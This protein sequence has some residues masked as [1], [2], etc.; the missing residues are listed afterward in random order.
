[1]PT[2]KNR[3]ATKAQ[4]TLL[5]SVLA[6]GEIG[7]EIDTNKF[8]I[9]NGLS[10]WNQLKYFVDETLSSGSTRSLLNDQPARRLFEKELISVGSR[11]LIGVGLGASTWEGSVADGDRQ[12]SFLLEK[13]LQSS[14]NP[15]EIRG[16]YTTKVRGPWI[17]TG[18]TVGVDDLDMKK[19]LRLN[20]NATASHTSY[21]DCTGIDIY[22]ASGSGVGAFNVS[23]DGGAPQ[24]VTPSAIESYVGVWRSPVLTRG[25]HTFLITA[26]ADN[27]LLGNAYVRD[28]DERAGV[29]LLNF[30][31]AGG[32]TSSFLGSIATSTWERIDSIKPDFAV[33]SLGHNNIGATTTDK[34]KEDLGAICDRLQVAAG[35]PIWIAVLVQHSTDS[36]WLPYAQATEEFASTRMQ[37]CTLHSFREFFVNNTADAQATGEFHTD[38]LHLNNL[39]HRVA[40]FSIAD[41]MRLPSQ[42]TL[43]TKPATEALPSVV[44]NAPDITTGLRHRWIFDDIGVVGGGVIATVPAAVGSVSSAAIGN[45]TTGKQP[46]LLANAAGG[47]AAASFDRAQGHHLRSAMFANA[48]IIKQPATLVAVHR[49]K[50]ATAAGYVVTGGVVGTAQHMSLNADSPN[51]QVTAT[52]ANGGATLNSVG[53]PD[54]AWHVEVGVFDG[55]NS[56]LHVDARPP[57][58]GT[59]V[60]DVDGVLPRIT[61]GAN[62]AATASYLDGDV[63]EVRV[64]DR[65]LTVEQVDYL[66]V[67]L[68]SRYELS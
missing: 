59:I 16:G 55:T 31:R 36:R 45:G 56:R 1:M 9:G 2:I 13:M 53:T 61:V 8:K 38:N 30:G 19:M 46:I 18:S 11:P 65:A 33:V 27:V 51:F 44:P 28:Q 60:N 32:G 43:P 4:W 57:V 24:T 29:R 62:P 41:S 68:T 67:E 12:I 26:L 48:D 10:T 5:N 47:H 23:V 21:Q 64:Y 58:T 25:K 6:A 7:L 52:A 63:L 14:Y 34:L 15:P 49:R 50:V 54:T 35:R 3:R 40:A 37:V 39:G 42:Q 17:K 20:L 22:Y 66:R